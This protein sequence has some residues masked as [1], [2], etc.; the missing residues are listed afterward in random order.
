MKP[1]GKSRSRDSKQ[2][3]LKPRTAGNVNKR[4]GRPPP[5]AG[6]LEG[7]VDFEKKKRSLEVRFED[8]VPSFP[9]GGGK[10]V[11][12][13]EE[14]DEVEAEYEAD[15]IRKYTKKKHTK[16][17][18]KSQ[19][20]EDDMGSLF[21]DTIVGKLPRFANRITL[22]N[23]SPGMKLWGFIAE[24][25]EKD[26]AIS[27]PGGLRGL[28]RACD[29]SDLIQ[30][31]KDKDAESFLP[32]MFE[33]GQLVSC[34]VLKFDDEKKEKGKR[35]IWLSLHLSLLHKGFTF[36]A[37]NEG[38]FLGAYVKSIEDHGYLLDFGL[39]SFTGFLPRTCSSDKGEINLK[40]RQL[41]HGIVRSIDKVRRVI[42]LNADPDTL[43]KSVIKDNKGVSFDLLVPGMLVNARV[44]ST[45]ENGIMLSFLTHF[46]GTADLF[47]L[48]NPFATAN[49]KDNYTT[50][51]KVNARILFTDPTTRAVGLTLNPHLVHSM[52][53]EA[54]VK[55]G[56]IYD[57]AKVVRVDRGL[58]LLLEIPSAPT[59]VPA[60]VGIHD[61]A[62][63]EVKKMEKKFKESSLVRARIIGFRHLD[64][65]AT[66]TLK[67]SVLEGSVFTH[68]DVKPGMLVRAK[69]IA[70]DTFGALVQLSSGVKAL[71]PLPHMSEF[72]VARP[73][74][75]FKVGADMLFRVLGCKSKRITVTHK[76]TLVKSKL[77]ILSSY[78]DASAGLVTHGW[79][80]KIEKHGCFV[81]FYNGVQGFVPRSELGLDPGSEA[82]SSYHVGQ[83][84][85]CRVVSA[86]PASHRLNLSFIIKPLS[87]SADDMVKLGSLVSG[88]VEKVTSESVVVSVKSEGY[89]KGSILTEHLS[90]HRGLGDLMKSALKPGYEFDKLLVLDV[91]GNNLVLTAKHSMINSDTK[92]PSEHSDVQPNSVIHGYI[93][94]IIEAGCF[95]RFLGRLTGFAP[96]RKAVED[97][98][99][100]LSEVFHVGQSVRSNILDVASDTGR[101][102]LSLKQSFCSSTNASFLKEYFM[103]DEKVAKLQLA[104]SEG[105][106]LNWVDDFPIGNVI[107]GT[108][109]EVKDFGVVVRFKKYSDVYGFITHYQLGGNSAIKD[110]QVQAVVLDIAMVEH[111]VDLS[112]KP[113][114]INKVS[115][116]DLTGLKQKKRKRGIQKDLQLHQ[117]VNAVVEIVKDN[118]LALSLPEYGNAIG[119]ASV[120]DYNTQNRPKDHFVNGQSVV[121][122]IMDLPVSSESGR[123]LLLLTSMSETSNPNKAKR[124][125]NYDTGSM[126]QA[127]ITETKPL[128]LRVKFGSNFHGRIHIT[129]ITD[130]EA[131]ES[132]FSSFKIGQSITARI[133]GKVKK[134]DNRRSNCQWDL[135]LKP[136]IVT[137]STDE[138]VD[139]KTDMFHFLVGQPVS[140]Y[141]SK[142][143]SEWVWL[144]VS[145]CVNA[146]IFR[147]DSSTEPTE[148][149]N[150]E[151]RFH[152]GQA[153]SGYVLAIKQEKKLLRLVPRVLNIVDNNPAGVD[154]LSNENLTANIREGTLVGGR[155]S[156][157]LPNVGGLLVQIGPHLYG[158][159]HYTEL[160]DMWVS[161]PLSGYHVGQFVRCMVLE[162]S[163][164]GKNT[165]HVDLSLRSSLVGDCNPG[166]NVHGPFSNT[167]FERIEDVHP[168]MAVQGYVKSI[169]SKGCFIMLSR[170]F[171]AK[172]L[173]SNLSGG[174]VEDLNKEFPV[175]KLVAGR[176]I[177]VEP[178]AKR[179]EVTLK[180]TDTGSVKSDTSH[181]S[182]LSTGQIICGVI[183]RV[184]QFGLFI[185]IERS[186]L[187]GLC[188]VS[189]ISDDL[190]DNPETI[191]KA[192]DVVR[193]KILKVDVESQRISLGMKNSYFK[194]SIEV[195]LGER[196]HETVSR[197][198][199]G[200]ETQL[201]L[202]PEIN[203]DENS[204]LH[205][206]FEMPELPTFTEAESRAFIPPL[207]VTLEEMEHPEEDN[208]LN[209]NDSNMNEVNLTS[210]KVKRVNK[211]KAKEERER[212]ISAA[213]EKQLEG[214]IPRTSDDYEKLVR[215]SPSSSIVWINYIK[216]FIDMGDIEKARSV[217]ERAVRTINYREETETLNAWVAYINLENKFGNPPEEAVQRVFERALQHCDPEKLHLA[218]FDV[219]ERTG[220]STLANELIDKMTKK[221]F[222]KSSEVWL[223][224]VRWFLKQH[225][226]GSK[227]VVSRALLSLP[228]E[229][230][231]DFISKAAILEYKLGSP[232]SGRFFF[233]GILKEYPKRTDLWSVY[234]DQEIRLGD[235]DI[236]RALFERAISLSLKVEKMKFLFK[237]YLE[238]EKSMGDDERIEHVKMK[239]MEFVESHAQ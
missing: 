60:Y 145:R 6:K 174:F 185:R 217:A 169:M 41:V 95:V 98:K 195:P 233:E 9:R 191:Y 180:T 181:I 108:V 47:H 130:E 12:T 51:K 160:T 1:S 66:A 92:L 175:G 74:K 2:H 91:E 87:K 148:L 19:D 110:S 131:C 164:S 42:H 222:K 211:K 86:V 219:Y 68:S 103:T 4:K 129:E 213:E 166:Q 184:V 128:E 18:N 43:S 146:Q 17:Q 93:C 220:Q 209:S 161:E 200:L 162:V 115:T 76:R 55:I 61:L 238:Y 114:F 239:A 234:L 73:G 13:E 100:D 75:K 109:H 80:T 125:T 138:S 229:K 228:R 236:I 187:V 163:L 154:V 137:G 22:K 23:I 183:K 216:F 102:T 67:E 118:Y 11:A 63:E 10:S 96:K 24:V 124:R 197:N 231:I 168:D 69:V 31:F 15:Q 56:D 25:N 194:P 155:I 121:A 159:V 205:M 3:S 156:Q 192:G 235:A 142:V 225:P 147:L 104:N 34:I 223:R 172:I 46:T 7:G 28:V 189:E 85:K 113:E 150:F 20:E 116:K 94:N 158:K 165:I 149:Q 230:H 105:A 177:S 50:N 29:A 57:C 143:D 72:D 65:L 40:F 112:L 90:D 54:N 127:E 84:V 81:K 64:G 186:N 140:G 133:V 215:V 38:M 48:Q 77:H 88:V 36:D 135:S 58:G 97:E 62:D 182:S 123:L 44:K 32:S 111:L 212:E 157:I 170:K 35:K 224:R 49:W 203:C 226:E 208:I 199:S 204:T 70:L 37:I 117:T 14:I 30:D 8:D 207:E 5:A 237:K 151:K 126:V 206:D 218:L 232:D 119:Y 136:S 193:A 26:L 153:I 227:D 27:L 33:V 21:G 45:L 101:I 16:K 201:A 198:D 71:C 210:N 89:L 106:N 167:R 152:V 141:V 134:A 173:L 120:I 221:L 139:L 78:A 107:E 79:I 179:V 188:H 190:I 178:L 196:N 52:A 39:P 82:S 122:T 132:P 99:V 176:V 214:D 59:S 202:S 144:T 83:V 171:D 53:P